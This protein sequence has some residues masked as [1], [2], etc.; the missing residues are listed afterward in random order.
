M[1]SNYGIDAAAFSHRAGEYF[2]ANYKGENRVTKLYQAASKLGFSSAVISPSID[3]EVI[4]PYSSTR[5]SQI[6]TIDSYILTQF[7]LSYVLSNNIKCP[8]IK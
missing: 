8:V 3:A 7:T 6:K 1:V 5:G 2:P 4:H